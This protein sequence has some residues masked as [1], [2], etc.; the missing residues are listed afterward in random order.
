M[1]SNP[2]ESITDLHS[3]IKQYIRPDD[4]KAWKALG[5]TLILD[6]IALTLIYL[7]LGLIGWPM[8]S[9]TLIRAFVQMHDMAH[10]SYFSSL[11]VN[12]IMGHIIGVIVHYPF[13]MWRDGHN[14]HHKH[15]G[16]L[17]RLDLS[18]TILFTKKQYDSWPHSKKLLVRIFR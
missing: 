7:N 14:H 13:D 4:S 15:F 16:N 2:E 1:T 10:F 12:K 5:V 18:Q 11:Q 17:D 9:L 3:H 6:V 8:H